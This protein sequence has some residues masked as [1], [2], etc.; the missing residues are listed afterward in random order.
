VPEVAEKPRRGIARG[1]RLAVQG[2]G[3]GGGLVGE[4]RALGVS[5]THC[6]QRNGSVSLFSIF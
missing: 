2:N 5:A 6:G 1:W 4:A 3:G